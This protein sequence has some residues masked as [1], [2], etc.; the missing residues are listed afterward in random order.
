MLQRTKLQ[1]FEDIVC[2]ALAFT[3]ATSASIPDHIMVKA[4]SLGS[5]KI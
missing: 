2:Y 1:E 3:E 4:E 5:R